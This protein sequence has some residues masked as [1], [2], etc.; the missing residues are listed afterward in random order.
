[1]AQGQFT[2]GE[3]VNVDREFSRRNKAIYL[4]K[5]IHLEIA[6]MIIIKLLESLRSQ[7]IMAIY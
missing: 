6:N 7:S 2:H 4:L 5:V 3:W 1:M